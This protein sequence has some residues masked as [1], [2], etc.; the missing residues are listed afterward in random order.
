MGHGAVLEEP[1]KPTT[2]AEG[3][4]EFRATL[5][6]TDGDEWRMPGF[7]VVDLDGPA[8]TVRYLDMNGNVWGA[9]DTL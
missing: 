3:V 8:A 5:H 1:A 9:P 6:D 2:P 7:P 4:A